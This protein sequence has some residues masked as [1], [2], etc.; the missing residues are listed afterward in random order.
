MPETW[1]DRVASHP[2]VRRLKELVGGSVRRPIWWKLNESSP[3]AL[4]YQEASRVCSFV[5]QSPDNRRTCQGRFLEALEQARATQKPVQFICPIQRYAVCLPVQQNGRTQG[6]LAVCHSQGAFP[7]TTVDLADLLLQTAAQELERSDEL[8]N[9]SEAIQPRCVALSTIHTIHR[10]ISSTLNLEELL[11]RV[12]RL[13]SQ[14]LRADSCAIWLVERDKKV[15]VPRA[16]VDLKKR[17]RPALRIR[18]C[19]MG[20]GLV[21]RIA[22]K[23]QFTRSQ[24]FMAV[25]LMEEEC[26]GVILVRRASSS[27]VFSPL[28]QEILSTLAEQAVVAIRNA[29]MYESQ[30][31]V[32]WGTIRSLSAI[33]DGMDP[34]APGGLSRRRVMAEL[35]L[36]IAQ[37]LGLPESQQKPLQYAALL[38]DAG[39]VGISEEILKKPTPLE[40]AE[41]AKVKEH[42]IQGAKLLAPLEVLE[43]AI[44][45]ILH[46]HER[47]DGTGY[48]KGLK[49]EAIPL[50]ARILAVANAFEAMVC[51]RPYRQAMSAEKAAR[52]I[53]S[54]AGTQF[55]P[56]V[57]HAFLSLARSGKLNGILRGAPGSS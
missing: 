32:T 36:R 48:P 22:S 4:D 37:K 33:L 8:K 49:K 46:H 19:R 2:S 20:V 31:R 41:F 47:Y 7:R 51:H 43:P 42:P 26:L 23:C 44:P 34:Y 28:D 52:E 24:R 12:A 18:P 11:P 45:I 3:K 40:P 56:K 30:E 57:V 21:G 1:L 14:V 50:G 9:L 53:E 38:H 13:C 10:L 5:R 16:L 15:L 35:A 6:H 29:Q 25:P 39:R 17:P 55:D 54:H 27:S